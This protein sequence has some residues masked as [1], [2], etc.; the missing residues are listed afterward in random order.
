MKIQIPNDLR[1]ELNATL[2]GDYEDSGYTAET[3][4]EALLERMG[5]WGVLDFHVQTGRIELSKEN[6]AKLEAWRVSPEG[7]PIH[8][9]T[10]RLL[11]DRRREGFH[12][13]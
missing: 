11:A 5:V 2:E 3:L 8:N 6:Q 9:A 1:D 12:I 4:I 7:Q 10:S 13:A